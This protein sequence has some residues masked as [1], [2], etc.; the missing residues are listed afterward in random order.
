[1]G[2][3]IVGYKGLG[4]RLGRLGGCGGAKARPR[5]RSWSANRLGVGTLPRWQCRVIKNQSEEGHVVKALD[6]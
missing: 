5:A 1:M 2:F 6:L 4:W 3:G